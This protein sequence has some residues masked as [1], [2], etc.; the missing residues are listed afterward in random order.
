MDIKN[1]RENAAANAVAAHLT[2]VLDIAM[3]ARRWDDGTENAM[4]DFYIEGDGRKVALEVT[5]IAD[6]CRVGRDIRWERVAPGGSIKVEGLSGCWILGHQGDVEASD[7]IQAIQDH[8]PQ[9]EALGV[10]RVDARSWQQHMFAPES[11]RPVDYEHLRALNLVGIVQADCVT[12][13]SQMRVG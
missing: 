13:S 8:L 7:V 11:L 6:G 2:V 9:L 1:S 3:T 5:T 4:H 10:L 12:G